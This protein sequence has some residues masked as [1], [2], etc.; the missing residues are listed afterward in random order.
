MAGAVTQDA[1]PVISLRP[2]V[3]T[4]CARSGTAYLGKV[5]G[6]LGLRFGHEVV[7]GPRTRAFP[8]WQGQHGDA[9][10]LAA[11]FLTQLGQDVL[12]HH[13]VRHP[14]KVVRS[15]VGVRFFAD[16]NASF[17][18]A[19]DA[20]TRAKWAVRQRLEAAGH[21][22]ES[23]KGPRPHKVYRAYLA[24]F[25]P[26]LWDE[27]TET[28]RALRYWVQWT[29]MI[30]ETAPQLDYRRLPLELLDAERLAAVLR[31]VGLEIDAGH[32]ALAM[33]KVSDSF[34]TRRVAHNL[35]W[36]D[37]PRTRLRREAE[38]LASELGYDVTDPTR[39]PVAPDNGSV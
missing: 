15:L 10:W 28:E 23:H 18:H 9:S 1:P 30:L 6:G 3:V 26:G 13:Q 14:L 33:S 17:L 12:V 31:A 36:D 29:R 34:N 5:V 19:D 37:F 11:P 4:G 35:E 7:F 27:A 21:V 32:V 16:R 38:E 20:W 24:E 2:L 8:G 39:R 25:A 22:E